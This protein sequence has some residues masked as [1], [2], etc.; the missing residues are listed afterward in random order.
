LFSKKTH[1]HQKRKGQAFFR[2]STLTDL[3]HMTIHFNFRFKFSLLLLLLILSFYIKTG[4]VEA[5]CS[6]STQCCTK[7][8][9]KCNTWYNGTCVKR[10]SFLSCVQ[11]STYNCG[12]VMYAGAN[13]CAVICPNVMGG[14]TSGFTEKG[15][16]VTSTAT[17]TPKPT[18]TP[19]PK[20]TATPTPKP[21]A[22][23]TPK[24]TATPTPS[25]TCTPWE[26]KGCGQ[27]G[28]ALNRMYVTRTCN[29]NYCKVTDCIVHSECVSSCTISLSPSPL[30]VGFQKG[31][32]LTADVDFRNSIVSRVNFSSSN[33][34]IATV[35]PAQDDNIPYVTTV[36]GVALGNTS[37]TATATLS[38]EG[39]CNTNVRVTVR[40]TAWFQTQGGNVHA[41]TN[42]STDI[43]ETTDDRN[44]STKLDNW[45]GIITHQ[46]QDGVNLGEGYPSND[47]PAHWLVESSYEAKPYG[48]FQF[49]RKKFA[50]DLATETYVQGRNDLPTE[51]GVYYAQSSR[52]LSGSSWDV[53]SSNRWVVLLVEGDVNINSNIRL[54]KG[55]FLA[56]A[57]TGD[58]NIADGVG[59]VHGIFVADGAISTGAGEEEFKGEGVFAAGSFDLGR[60]FE[61][62]RNDSTPVEFFK[63]RP[64]FIMS[65]YKDKDRNLWWFFGK[66]QEIAP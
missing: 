30:N 5:A 37:V 57:A 6:G 13:R 19:T 55:S 62:D 64:D 63:A 65:S 53:S 56:I 18:A 44:F 2:L 27:G 7:A 16:K 17:P 66:W 39:S 21:T 42:L 14:G 43:P 31:W 32:N 3:D 34:S 4:E 35:N 46:D 54:P 48:S 36:Y 45:P 33:T 51:D 49:F 60:D 20:P 12:Y 22:T 23:P 52:T 26:N 61:D 9:Y 8:E 29:Y 10:D 38:P 50:M 28:C 15:C 58:I 59:Q 41:G 11:Y 1:I 25:C 24:P 47:T 40:P